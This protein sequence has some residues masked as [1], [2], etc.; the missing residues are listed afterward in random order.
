MQP[1]KTEEALLDKRLD[2]ICEGLTEAVDREVARRKREG[3]PIY[4]SENGKVVDVQK[5]TQPERHS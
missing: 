1:S 3:L 4:I 2:D 5:K